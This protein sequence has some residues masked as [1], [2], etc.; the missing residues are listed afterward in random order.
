MEASQ[1]E[2]SGRPQKRPIEVGYP[3]L[4]MDRDNSEE[5]SEKMYWNESI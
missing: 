3:Q 2:A 5:F 1:R 4:K